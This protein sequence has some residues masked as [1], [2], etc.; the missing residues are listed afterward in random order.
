MTRYASGVA[1]GKPPVVG[2]PLRLSLER[3]VYDS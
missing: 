2:R 1:G 3:L